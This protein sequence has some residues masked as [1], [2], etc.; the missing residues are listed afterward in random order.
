MICFGNTKRIEGKCEP[1]NYFTQII[2]TNLMPHV[3]YLIENV[4]FLLRKAHK[5]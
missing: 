4:R 2:H 3:G 5:E 1:I